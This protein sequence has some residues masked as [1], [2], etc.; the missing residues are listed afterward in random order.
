GKVRP[1]AADGG[2]NA[3]AIRTNESTHHRNL[4]GFKQ[5][6]DLLAQALVGFLKLRNRAHIGAVG[7]QILTGID[8]NAGQAARGESGG[9]NF[10]RKHLAV[11]SDVVVGAGSDFADRAN[12]AQQ[13]IQ[14]FEVGAEVAVEFGEQGGAEQFSGGIVVAFAQ[15]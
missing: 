5:R 8:M 11:G 10:A 12:A 1:A 9:D 3:G 2:R 7:E 4:A 14:L 15:G 6:L 13:F